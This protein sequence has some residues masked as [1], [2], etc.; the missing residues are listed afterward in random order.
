MIVDCNI[1]LKRQDNERI[2]GME[3][4]AH[5][6]IGD[7]AQFC[8][9]PRGAVVASLDHSGRPW[10]RAIRYPGEIWKVIGYI[11]LRNDEQAWNTMEGDDGAD[12]V[13]LFVDDTLSRTPP[14]EAAAIVAG[15]HPRAER[16]R[17]RT[18]ELESG[19]YVTT[20]YFGDEEEPLIIDGPFTEFSAVLER[21]S[22]IQQRSAGPSALF[23][24][25]VDAPPLIAT[26]ASGDALR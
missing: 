10:V 5:I 13:R 23:L 21:R 15:D 14:Q 2:T 22:H 11:G 4:P 24:D 19:W 17:R 9:Q 12:M 18:A 25:V 8:A 7:F 20:G 1:D 16:I 26:C 6:P 3:E